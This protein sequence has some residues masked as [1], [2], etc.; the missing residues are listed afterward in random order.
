MW[1]PHGHHM[2]S[3]WIPCGFHVY[4][5]WFP[6]GHNMVS[7]VD[8]TWFP[9]GHHVVSRKPHINQHKKQL[10]MKGGNHEVNM[11]SW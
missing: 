9:H 3:M 7:N 5:M 11:K 8:T 1:L 10:C 2:V 6:G 4:T